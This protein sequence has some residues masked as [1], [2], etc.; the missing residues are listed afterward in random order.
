MSNSLEQ[1]IKSLEIPDRLPLLPV[2]DLVVFPY[3]VLPLFVGREISI[4]AIETALSGNRM[5][6]LATQRSLDI[7]TPAPRDIY[8]VGTVGVIMR[9]LKLPDGR[10]KILVQG[11]SKVR[12]EAFEQTSPFFAAKVERISEPHPKEITL[13]IEALMRA[14]KERL[15][16]VIG[17]GKVLASEILVVIENL[18]E[19]GR[20][21]DMIASNLGLKVE[22]AQEVLEITDPVL[23]LR[24]VNEILSKE[25]EV[26]TVQQKIQTEAKS[27]IDKTQREYYLREQIKAIQK[28]LGEVDER[29]EEINEFRKKIEEAAMPEK[30]AGEADKQLRRLER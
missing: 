14:V 18:E 1:D 6:L 12:I 15:E 5:V 17:F 10:V 24:R 23:R 26:L 25:L 30:V 27:E 8:T 21:A 28:E 3:M 19:P 7:E 4:R 9:M 13:D 2:R 29:L 20:L 16:K 22:T 11:L